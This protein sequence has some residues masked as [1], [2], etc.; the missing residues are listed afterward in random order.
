MHDANS[1]NRYLVGTI[2][3]LSENSKA[4]SVGLTDMFVI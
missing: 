4:I 3:F 2:L 1:N